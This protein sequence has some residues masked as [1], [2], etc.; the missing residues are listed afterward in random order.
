MYSQVTYFHFSLIHTILLSLD[1]Y[2]SSL[3]LDSWE[4]VVVDGGC[5]VR[6]RFVLLELSN[7]LRIFELDQV[8]IDSE[9]GREVERGGHVG[10]VLGRSEGAKSGVLRLYGGRRMRGGHEVASR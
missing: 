5:Y 10:K 2:L 7:P 8:D 1:L 3:S 9:L 4:N 6:S